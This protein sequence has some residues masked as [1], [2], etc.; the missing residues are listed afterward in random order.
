MDHFLLGLLEPGLVGDDPGSAEGREETPAVRLVET[1]RAIVTEVELSEIALVPAVCE[2][3]AQAGIAGRQGELQGTGVS[4]QLLTGCQDQKAGHG[5]ASELTV[6]IE[7]A[8]G[9]HRIGN[10]LRSFRILEIIG[11]RLIDA[12]NVILAGIGVIAIHHIPIRGER[13]VYRIIGQPGQ[14]EE[15]HKLQTLRNEIQILVD[16]NRSDHLR[17]LQV[18]V[19]TDEVGVGVGIGAVLVVAEH[20][21]LDTDMVIIL[22]VVSRKQ[23]GVGVDDLPING[24]TTVERSR[25]IREIA[26]QADGQLGRLRDIDI[27]V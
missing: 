19:A 5:I 21:V 17:T 12:G 16:F 13:T 3:A 22:R 9:I 25:V 11:T 27:D 15:R 20:D 23:D 6:I 7:T 2:A 18:T 14:I 8:L 1:L 4:R 10:G 24:V 26:G